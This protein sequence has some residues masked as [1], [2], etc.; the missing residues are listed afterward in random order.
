MECGWTGKGRGGLEG[1]GGSELH[2]QSQDSGSPCAPAC[3]GLCHH[4][5]SPATCRSSPQHVRRHQE[6]CCPESRELEKVLGTADDGRCR[7]GTG[8]RRGGGGT[9]HRG[10]E[11]QQEC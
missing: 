4:P 9:C 8:P 2:L 11:G 1:R 3:D 6:H 7:G 5:L 10:A